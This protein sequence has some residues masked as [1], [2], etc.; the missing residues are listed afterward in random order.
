M[1][2][3]V[4]EEIVEMIDYVLSRSDVKK[5][6]KGKDAI[7]GGDEIAQEL[8]NVKSESVKKMLLKLKEENDKNRNVE[9]VKK[10]GRVLLKES[11][12]KKIIS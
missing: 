10:Y 11:L 9:L 3:G 6:M 8:N 2:K 12:Y 5:S 1:N 4:K 7:G